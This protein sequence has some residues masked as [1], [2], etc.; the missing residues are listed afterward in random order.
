MSILHRDHVLRNFQGWNIQYNCEWNQRDLIVNLQINDGFEISKE[1]KIED[2]KFL[3]STYQKNI[4]K[5]TNIILERQFHNIKKNKNNDI[6]IS[7][8]YL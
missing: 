6:L 1:T 2:I 8:K 4:Y 3:N 5:Q 7:K